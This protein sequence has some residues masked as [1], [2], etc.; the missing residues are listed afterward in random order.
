LRILWASNAPWTPTGYGMQTAQVAKRLV[1]DGHDV[2]IAANHGI[3]GAAIPWGNIPVFPN[4]LDVYGNDAIPYAYLRHEADLAITLFDVWVYKNPDLDNARIYPWTPVDHAPVPPE[5]V[6][7]TRKHRPIAMSRFGVEQLRE[8]G[9]SPL[10]VPHAYEPAHFAPVESRLRAAL[11]V[12]DDAFL[13]TI[14]AAN[15][16]T[17]PPRKAWGENLFAFGAFA[18]RHPDAYLYLHTDLIG[19]D[20]VPLTILLNELGLGADRVK[21]AP[22]M[23]LRMGEITPPMLAQVYSAS[24]VLLACS[25]GEGFGVPVLEA[26]ACGIPVIVSD[27]SAQAELCGAGWKV[28]TQPWWDLTQGAWFHQPIVADI[29]RKLEAAYEARGTLR[30]RAI[31]FAA[32]YEAD[33]IYERYWRPVL[34]E[35]ADEIAT[36]KLSRRERRAKA[37]AA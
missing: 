16:G 18:K 36:S 5:V 37:K 15:K 10:Y 31:D 19:H 22:Q 12:P 6:A 9:V 17:K 2:A 35:I 21:F 25:Y 23:E 29:I 7:F 13:V 20:G 4:G 33:T 27:G 34:A 1:A 28:A 24:D 3:A 14:N 26:Q 8:A 32:D 11:G 30:Q